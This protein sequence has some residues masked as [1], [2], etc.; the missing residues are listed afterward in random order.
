MNL[1]EL[2]KNKFSC[3][4]QAWADVVILVLDFVRIICF[5]PSKDSG[6]HFDRFASSLTNSGFWNRQMQRIS[7]D[8][9]HPM[10]RI[11]DSDVTK[12]EIPSLRDC[13]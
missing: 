6:Q 3:E 13:K 4:S 5:P 7:I 1:S 12:V 10:G 2:H 11:V 9:N 8:L